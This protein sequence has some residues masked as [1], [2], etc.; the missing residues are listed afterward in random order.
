MCCSPTER[1]LIVRTFLP[2]RYC[3]PVN[4]L[5]A[6]RLLHPRSGLERSDFVLWPFCD[7]RNPSNVRNAPK[8]TALTGLKNS[9][10]SNAG[11]WLWL[12]IPLIENLKTLIFLLHLTRSS[13]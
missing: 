10:T 2:P 8:P 13:L 11:D 5:P 6:A 12:E 7:P 9:T 1:S 4:R 3:C